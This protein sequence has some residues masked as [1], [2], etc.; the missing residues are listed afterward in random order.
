MFVCSGLLFVVLLFGIN[1]AH[2][3]QRGSLPVVMASAMERPHADM[4]SEEKVIGDE[5]VETAKHVHTIENLPDPDAGLSEEERAAH[6]CRL[7]PIQS[8]SV[9]VPK[10]LT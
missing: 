5:K 9:S 8:A 10:Q 6:V 2:P 7:Q 3:T 4:S 1:T